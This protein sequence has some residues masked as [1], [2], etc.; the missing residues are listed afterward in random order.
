MRYFV[1]LFITILLIGCSQDKEVI[2][3]V[4]NNANRYSSLQETNY[5]QTDKA[6]IYLQKQ[7]KNEYI[8]KINPKNIDDDIFLVN[9]KNA[10]IQDDNT[11]SINLPSWMLSYF[12]TTGSKKLE[13]TL[14][15][16]EIFTF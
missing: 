2:S 1:L 9:C 3:M 16:N 6:I 12:V 15:N 8:V 13:C 4:K 14:S 10:I 5:I 11:N 7:A